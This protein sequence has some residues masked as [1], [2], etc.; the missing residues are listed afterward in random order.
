MHPTKNDTILTYPGMLKL[1]TVRFKGMCKRHPGFDPMDGAGGVR[2]GC[3]R[4]ELLLEIHNTHLR[5]VE[6]IVKAKNGEGP[7]LVRRT[8]AKEE[9]RQ[10]SLF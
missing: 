8:A 5:L 1:G 2:G 4:C 10:P 6:L 3:K 9:I 7:A